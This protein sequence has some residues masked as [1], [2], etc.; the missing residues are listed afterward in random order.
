M[1]PAND[2][3]GRATVD[4]G[5]ELPAGE[6]ARKRHGGGASFEHSEISECE[7]QPLGVFEEGHDTVAYGD[8]PV[9]QITG[10]NVRPRFPFAIRHRT[11]AVDHERDPV[12]FRDCSGPQQVRHESRLVT[13]NA[14]GYGDIT[15]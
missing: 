13:G 14:I 10:N 3:H 6:S 9:N 4:D 5:R 2:P 8:S 7:V 12:R 15:G 11:A 1:L